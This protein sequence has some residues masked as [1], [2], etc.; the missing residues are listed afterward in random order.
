MHG[1]GESSFSRHLGDCGLLRYEH[2]VTTPIYFVVLETQ[3]PSRTVELC[4]VL[5]RAASADTRETV[6]SS[7]ISSQLQRFVVPETRSPPRTV[8]LC[9]VLEKAAS[10]DTWETTVSSAGKTQSTCGVE[11]AVSYRALL[12]QFRF[13]AHAVSSR[14]GV[15]P[16]NNCIHNCPRAR[17]HAY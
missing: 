15:R 2:T 5:D 6:V 17:R 10:V 12:F 3:S 1:V 14:R 7:A 11:T 9:M 16:W 8:E 4:M 13:G